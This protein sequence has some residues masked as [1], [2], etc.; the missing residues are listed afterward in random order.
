MEEVGVRAA[1]I[2]AL[3]PLCHADEAKLVPA[4]AGHMVAAFCLFDEHATGGTALPVLEVSLKVGVAGPAVLDQHALATKLCSATFADEGLS[5]VDDPAAVLVGTEAQAGIADCL[6]PKQ[7]SS[8]ALFVVFRQVEVARSRDI[9]HDWTIFLRTSHLF[10]DC[11]LVYEV[12]VQASPT[13]LVLALADSAHLVCLETSLAQL[14]H[15]SCESASHDDVLKV[16][17][18]DLFVRG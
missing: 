13:K 3:F 1:L 2:V 8:I 18:F 15:Y 9:Q 10:H 14:T 4:D 11:D 5:G 12:V 7:K 17:F 6:F 16:E